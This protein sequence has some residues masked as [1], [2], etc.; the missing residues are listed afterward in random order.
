MDVDVG[1]LA[2]LCSA[3]IYWGNAILTTLLWYRCLAMR[4][5]SDRNWT[6]CCLP[7]SVAF[8]LKAAHT[9]IA[10]VTLWVTPRTV[11]P[12]GEGV[13]L[14]VSLFLCSSL[15]GL[16]VCLGQERKHQHQSTRS[17]AWSP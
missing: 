11:D 4:A 3:C 7:A 9:T 1:F 13:S 14:L 12:I 15:V 5:C 10:V 8:S 17:H 16:W 6:W 2:L